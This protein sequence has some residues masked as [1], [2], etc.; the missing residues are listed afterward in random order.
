[1]TYAA[2]AKFRHQHTRREREI[3]RRAYI[4]QCIANLDDVIKRVGY[5][6]PDL[7]IGPVAI[8]NCRKAVAKAWR[9]TDL[10]IVDCFEAVG[11]VAPGLPAPTADDAKRLICG[12]TGE[13]PQAM[14]ERHY[15]HDEFRYTHKFLRAN[16]Y[17]NATIAAALQWPVMAA[18]NLE[19]T[20]GMGVEALGR[21][22][23]AMVMQEYNVTWDRFTSRSRHPTL[24][25]SRRLYYYLS[26]TLTDL[27]YPTIAGIA[28]VANHSSVV[29]SFQKL[30]IAMEANAKVHIAPGVIVKARSEVGRVNALVQRDMH[31]RERYSVTAPDKASVK[32]NG[33]A[34]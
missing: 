34:A 6:D 16:G 17:D 19:G 2:H 14:I 13:C 8:L 22:I 23:M 25:W 5:H 32:V 18:W 21:A 1:M 3:F 27:S 33:V 31:S 9:P 28:G 29:T 20:K 30:E 15:S 7:V 10:P 26:R 11:D 12:L 24:V 4:G